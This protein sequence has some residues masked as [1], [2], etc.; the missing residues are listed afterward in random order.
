MAALALPLAAA[1]AP[2]H[3]PPDF[4]T[5]LQGVIATAPGAY[6]TED[7]LCCAKDSPGCQVVTQSMG[8]DIFQQGSRNR[9]LHRGAQAVLEWAAPVHKIMALVPG[10]AINSTHKWACAE[11]CPTTDDFVSEVVIAPFHEPVKYIGKRVVDQPKSAGGSTTSCDAFEWTSKVWKI[12]PVSTEVFYIDS[13]DPSSPVP[14]KHS[15]TFTQEIMKITH[16]AS[17]TR[18]MSYINFDASYPV[19]AELDVDPDSLTSCKKL[20][21][22]TQD[23]PDAPGAAL[24]RLAKAHAVPKSLAERA[25]ARLAAMSEA[26]RASAEAQLLEEERERALRK[27]AGPTPVFAPSY[28]ARKVLSMFMGEG[29]F[30]SSGGDSCCSLVGAPVCETSVSHSR[31]TEYQDVEAKQIRTE[32]DDGTVVVSDYVRNRS[33]LVNVSGSVDTC[34]SYCPIP[35][36]VDRP[37]ARALPSDYVDKGA[38]TLDGQQVEEYEWSET[39]LKV[40]KLTT[41]RF[42]ARLSANGSAVPVFESEDLFPVGGKPLGVQN[43]TFESF[44]PGRPPAAKFTIAGA[45]TCPKAKHCEEPVGAFLTH[46]LVTGRARVW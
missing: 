5:G 34:I 11:Y 42:Y 14:F 45:D 35:D 22:D 29:S 18:N 43:L 12:L 9:T 27:R 7:A 20:D 4:Y 30:T 6:R 36:Y 2:P 46:R 3:L 31:T 16:E 39:V 21:P 19:A 17:S 32:D 41:T 10:S 26:S 13:A 1:L 8:A 25:A 44:V 28:T 38:V 33:M 37:S 23:C 24:A 40:I 15:S